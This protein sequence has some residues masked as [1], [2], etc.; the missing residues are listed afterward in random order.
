VANREGILDLDRYRATATVDTLA[1]AETE[2]REPEPA[3][4]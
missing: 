3:V 4:A 1:P 2:Q